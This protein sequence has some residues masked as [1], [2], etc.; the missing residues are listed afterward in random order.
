MGDI[1]ALEAQIAF[2]EEAVQALDDALAAQQQHVLRLERQIALLQQQLND[3]GARI[4]EVAAEP[5]EPLP[6]HY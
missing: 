1:A 3:Q 5:S 6:P 2:V 4:D